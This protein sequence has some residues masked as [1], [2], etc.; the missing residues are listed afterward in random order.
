MRQRIAY[1]HDTLIFGQLVKVNEEF[2]TQFKE[3]P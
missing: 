3:A 2:V 1:A